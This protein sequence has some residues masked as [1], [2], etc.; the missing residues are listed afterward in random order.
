MGK[1]MFAN[2]NTLALKSTQGF[3]SSLRRLVNVDWYFKVSPEGSSQ[4]ISQQQRYTR[5]TARG[6]PN[7]LLPGILLYRVFSKILLDRLGFDSMRVTKTVHRLCRI[8]WWRVCLAQTFLA[9]QN[10]LAQ[11]NYIQLFC[12]WASQVSCLFSSYF[13]WSDVS[14]EKNAFRL[15]QCVWASW[16]GWTE[17]QASVVY[18]LWL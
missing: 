9:R 4:Q 8:Y 15:G 2:R 6:F 13:S 14:S 7:I 1:A 17:E 5:H 11:T 16:T 3:L 18:Y 12:F 10:R